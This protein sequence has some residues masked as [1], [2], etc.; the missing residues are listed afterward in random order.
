MM[1]RG[2]ALARI[3]PLGG[4][5]MKRFILA[6]MASSVLA[7]AATA[8]DKPVIGPTPAWVKPVVIP[9]QSEKSDE[10]PLRILLSDQQ[11]ALETGRQTF[12]FAT[13]IKI[14]TSQ[15]LG[16]GNLSFPWRPD[17]DVLTVHKLAIRRGDKI[18]DVLASGQTFTV[19]RREQNLE[20]ATLDGVLTANIQ[21]EGLQVGDVLEYAV[22]I[23]SSDPVMKGHVEQIAGGW[24]GFP[25]GR[26]HL[27]MQWPAAMPARIRQTGSLP[28]LKPVKADGATS[29]ELTLDDMEPIIPAKGAPS[30]YQLIRLVELTDFASWADLGAL[31]APL[32]QKA[33]VIPPQGALRGELERIQKLSADPKVRA[34]AALALVQDRV[35]YVALSMGAGGY[36]PAD[37]E[38]TWSRRF[39]DCKA[40]TAML[41]ALLGAMGI[42]AEPVAV[43]SA[44]GDGVDARLPLVA[45][46]NHVLVRATIAGKTYWLDGTRIGDTSLDRL[47][48]PPFGWGLPLVAKGAALVRMVPAKLDV[49][50][51]ET[52]IQIDATAGISLPAPTRI[53]TIIRGDV[54]I[55]TNAEIASLTGEVRDRALKDYWKKEHDFID[56]T[57][58]SA[59]FD[60]RTGEMRLA[61]TG[62]AK[63]DWSS[64]WY[65]T[66]GTGIGYKA[67]FS[68]DPG[69]DKDAP[70]AVAYPFYNRVKETILLPPGF[71]ASA[72][73]RET[74]ENETVAGI[75]Y[76]RFGSFDSK[77]ITIEKTERSIAPEFPAKDA[78]AAQEKLRA[79]AK[80]TVYVQK[81]GG[82]KQ[83][84]QELSQA[85]AKTP[86]TGAEYLSRGTRF[87]AEERFDEAVKDFTEAK[88][89]DPTSPWPLANRAMAY[90][91]KSD[92]A[93]AT[94][95]I[96]AASAIDGNS[97]GVFQARA[98]L[99]QRRG[100]YQDAVNAYSAVLKVD[101]TSNWAL[102]NRAEMYH[103]IGINDLALQDVSAALKKNSGW[104]SLY[105]LRSN[106]LIGLGKPE[107]AIKGAELVTAAN[108][109]SAYAHV[110]AGNIFGRFGKHDAAMKAYGQAI[111]IKP[112][113][114]IYVNRAQ[115][116]RKVDLA[117]R[118]SDIDAALQ[119]EPLDA[120]ALIEKANI[121]ADK[122]DLVGSIA[123]Y[124]SALGKSPDDPARA[125]VR[126]GIAQTRMGHTALAEKDFTAARDKAVNGNAFNEMC[127]E[128]AT[129]GVALE[130]AL[131]DC[132]GALAKQPGDGTFL[133]SRALVLLRLG[134]FDEAIADYD[135]ALAK[136]PRQAPS[137]FGRAV[138]WSRKGDKAK[139][140]ADVAAAIAINPD[141]RADFE[142][143]GV[144]L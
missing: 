99:A 78:P 48:V 49:P 87:L 26:A 18:I 103:A 4:Y 46:F 137:L 138:A 117:G 40:K 34:E 86:T 91:G 47:A 51:Q 56:V 95:D 120:D 6:L 143:Y 20:S 45:L 124:S 35:R 23:S 108:P 98:A 127:W 116:R 12:Y 100:A 92:F 96:E 133:D 115:N 57:S 134:R 67:D 32:Y 43:S 53:E 104:I 64:G 101:P 102:G 66:D 107:E 11:V 3:G 82:Y 30:R 31:M 84:G 44:A 74:V 131:I 88:R 25:I 132:D 50:N 61:M 114:Y 68:R 126:R 135:R 113:A 140:D 1:T 73:R 8:A 13:A 7:G 5:L 136:F 41:L 60:P 83:T 109:D 55:G 65:E 125:L 52:S 58:T 79:L 27:R 105:L 36:V 111:A 112:E 33:A 123:A 15:G 139:S 62:L 118:L 94:A 80:A 38:V 24:N 141:V 17:T 54:A 128:K 29:V 16:V 142:G 122:G 75:E 9:A 70:F 121:L 144:K 93:A 22:S 37:P 72:L 39:G 59:S 21:P 85:L 129:A 42:Q 77:I 76:H 19:I 69:P 89:L 71:G 63:M 10:A 119:L 28:A 97:L 81:P 106:I 110:I 14:Q 2:A 130:S 90:V